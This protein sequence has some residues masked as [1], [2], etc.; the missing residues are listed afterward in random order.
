MTSSQCDEVKIEQ[1]ETLLR[2]PQD[3]KFPPKLTSRKPNPESY[4]LVQDRKAAKGERYR[5]KKTWHNPLRAH[6]DA[7]RSYEAQAL[8]KKPIL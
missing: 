4:G 5:L 1:D 2:L 6:P 7:Q 8:Q 3:Q